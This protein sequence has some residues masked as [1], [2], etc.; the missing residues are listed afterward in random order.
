MSRAQDRG[1]DGNFC[2]VFALDLNFNSL[3]VFEEEYLGTKPSFQ[4]KQN[5]GYHISGQFFMRQFPRGC[6]NLFTFRVR[7]F[8][9]K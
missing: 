8:F 2:T 3:K 4:T 7:N 5:A 9:L 1:T 6:R